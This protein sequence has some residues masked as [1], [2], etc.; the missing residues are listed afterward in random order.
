MGHSSNAVERRYPVVIQQRLQRD[1]VLIT[2]NSLHHFTAF[3]D[4][5]G[6][7]SGDAVFDSQLHIFAYVDFTDDRFAVVICCQFVNDWTQPLAGGSAIRPEIDQNRLLGSENIRFESVLR[8]ICSHM[9]TQVNGNRDPDSNG[10]GSSIQKIQSCNSQSY[11]QCLRL[12]DCQESILRSITGTVARCLERGLIED[13][14]VFPFPRG[15][16][17]QSFQDQFHRRD[18]KFARPASRQLDAGNWGLDNKLLPSIVPQRVTRK[19]GTDP[20]PRFCR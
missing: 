15:Q 8:K 3:E 1:F 13:F 5:D 20:V 9:D 10:T 4:Q 17:V 12:F 2:L 7:N 14:S 18:Q 6:W 19:S 11:R 16:R